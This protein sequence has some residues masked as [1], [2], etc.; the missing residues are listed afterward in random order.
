MNMTEAEAGDEANRITETL[1]TWLASGL[2]AVV[3]LSGG[4]D[5]DV[6]ARLVVRAVGRER[7]KVFTVIQDDMEA[8]HLQQARETAQDL[9][10]RLAEINLTGYPERFITAMSRADPDED[11]QPVGLLDPARAKCSLRTP[12]LSTYQDRGYC[13]MGTS[14]R[15]EIE[16]GFF[17]PLGDAVWHFGPIAHLYKSQ[18]IAVAR[19]V[20]TSDSVLRQPPSAGFWSGQE[21]LEDLSYWLFNAGPIGREREFTDEDLAQVYRI[22]AELTIDRVDRALLA[23]SRGLGDMQVAKASELPTSLVEGLRALTINAVRLKRR[24]LGTRL[25][26]LS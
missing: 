8:R 17:L 11:F 22:R 9:R 12:I 14:N 10:L 19:A 23:L 24:A 7:L 3:G 25:P 18:V 2:R 15:T 21:D 5:S 20:G 6:V 16:T 4:L 1:R 26:N 13:V